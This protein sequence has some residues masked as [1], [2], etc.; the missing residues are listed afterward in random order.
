M[1]NAV[2]PAG[3]VGLKF[4]RPKR[5]TFDTQIFRAASGRELRI[6]LMAYPL[7]EYDLKYEVLRDQPNV[8]VPSSPNNELKTLLGF[9][10]KR[11]AAGDSWLF[12]DSTDDAVTDETFGIGDGVATVYTLQ[13]AY[14]GF[15]EPVHNVNVLTNV[16][17][18]GVTLANPADYTIDAAGNVTFAVAPA[19]GATLSW[20]GSFYY[21]CR[22]QEDGADFTQFMANLWDAK[23]IS[24]VG[25]PANKL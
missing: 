5:P 20:T 10:L 15:A 4:D 24:F 8:A 6:S 7:W 11:Q 16:K 2:F 12:D 3:L 1:S 17:K 14:G 9:F 18:A 22:F 23:K 21:R 25:S 13:R 19:L